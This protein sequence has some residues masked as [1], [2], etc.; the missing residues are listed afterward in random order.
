MD[1]T[2]LKVVETEL[3]SGAAS[4]HLHEQHLLSGYE[5]DLSSRS[6]PVRSPATMHRPGSAFEAKQVVSV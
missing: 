1:K 3:L 2:V 6:A 4:P 5:S